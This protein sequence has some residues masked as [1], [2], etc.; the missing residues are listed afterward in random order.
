MAATATSRERMSPNS[1]GVRKSDD[2]PLALVGGGGGG[3]AEVGG[4]AP[5]VRERALA[6]AD[7]LRQRDGVGRERSPHVFAHEVGAF[8]EDDGSF[9]SPR[10]ARAAPELVAE[11]ERPG[12][13]GHVGEGD[14]EPAVG[15][16][17]VGRGGERGDVRRVEMGVGDREEAETVRGEC[18][19]DVD[20]QR[21]GL[22]PSV[23]F[24]SF[25]P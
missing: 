24:R 19:R 4:R 21:R 7:R 18:A 20:E 23:A 13:A 17:L 15:A 10:M 25:P 16:D 12:F 6:R 11:A 1:S 9:V 5:G 14:L 2:R 22:L 3:V 8:G